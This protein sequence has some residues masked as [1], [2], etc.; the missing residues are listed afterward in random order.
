MATNGGVSDAR[1]WSCPAPSRRLR[2]LDTS[3]ESMAHGNAHRGTGMEAHR[4]SMIIAGAI[5]AGFVLL[6]F[7]T[8]MKRTDFEAC[9]DRVT[10]AI[11]SD[12]ADRE[13]LVS[14]R[15]CSGIAS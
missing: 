1:P 14:A 15:M 13:S 8:C 9:F 3:G 2:F 11:Q 10:G 7:S 6:S 5:L 4:S 12:D